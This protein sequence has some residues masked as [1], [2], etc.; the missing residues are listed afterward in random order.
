M[1]KK[2]ADKGKGKGKEDDAVSELKKQLI[3]LDI[4]KD[5]MEKQLSHFINRYGSRKG[6]QIQR[7]H[8]PIL[9]GTGQNTDRFRGRKEN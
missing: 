2:K 5:S 8:Q 3:I 1:S 7:G 9:P 6:R 4:K